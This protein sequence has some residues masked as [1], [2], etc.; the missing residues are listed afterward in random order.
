MAFVARFNFN[1]T[2]FESFEAFDNCYYA[3][4][5][6]RQVHASVHVQM[7]CSACFMPTAVVISGVFAR[8]F[9][10]SCPCN[11]SLLCVADPIS[12]PSLSWLPGSSHAIIQSALTRLDICLHDTLAEVC[13][14]IVSFCGTLVMTPNVTQMHQEGDLS[15][16]MVLY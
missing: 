10:E 7:H 2:Q 9:L 14:H 13:T 15:E 12:V 4:Q 3:C 16:V 6:W 5:Q 11:P 1:N 8:L